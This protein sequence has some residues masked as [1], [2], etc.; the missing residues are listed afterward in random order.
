MII[1]IGAV[2]IGF[3]LAGILA[4]I[5]MAANK[6]KLKEMDRMIEDFESKKF[7]SVEEK[8][9]AKQKLKKDLVKI[10][11]G[12]VSDKKSITEAADKISIL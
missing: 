8:E 11:S 1:L 10:K 12:I 3:I 4:P 6:K 2:I 7:S 9:S 5:L